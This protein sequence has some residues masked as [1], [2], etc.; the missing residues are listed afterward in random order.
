MKKV[1]YIQASIQRRKDDDK[2]IMF[3]FQAEYAKA[4]IQAENEI[5]A[6]KMFNEKY[7]NFNKYDRDIWTYSCNIVEVTNELFEIEHVYCGQ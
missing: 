2:H 6:R 7:P 5:E 1:Y 3:V 4:I